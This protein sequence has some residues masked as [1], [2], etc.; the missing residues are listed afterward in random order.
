M[1]DKIAEADKELKRQIDKR[2]EASKLQQQLQTSVDK[3]RA[4]VEEYRANVAE[5]EKSITVEEKEYK[6]LNER[7]LALQAEFKNATQGLRDTQS[8]LASLE[9]SYERSKKELKRRMNFADAEKAKIPEVENDVIDATH[10]LRTLQREYEHIQ[11]HRTK[12]RK[13]VDILVH[14]VLVQES[15][16]TKLAKKLQDTLDVEASL[17]QEKT[18]WNKEEQLAQKQISALKAQRDLRNRELSRTQQR[19]KST[20]EE[21]LVKKLQLTDLTKQANETIAK[22]QNYSKLYES[23]KNERNSYVNAIQASSQALAE[24]KERVKILQNEVEILQNESIAKD[25][26]LSKERLAHADASVQRD[27]LRFETNKAHAT[28]KDKQRDVEQQIVRIDR[29]NSV[30]SNLEKAMLQL[31]KQYEK[32]VEDRNHTGIQLIDR[33]DEL[34]ILYE[35]SNVHEDTMRKGNESLAA[36]DVK[37]R[38]LQVRERDLERELDV[39][40]EKFPKM[41][42]VAEKVLRLQKQLASERKFTEK[43]SVELE[44][45]SH[46]K[47]WQPLEGYDADSDRLSEQVTALEERLNEKR[48]KLLERELVLEELNSLSE[49]LNEK[50]MEGKQT[51]NERVDQVHS[52]QSRLQNVTKKMMSLVSELSMYQAT[53]MKLEEQKAERQKEV[54]EA[55]NRLQRGEVPSE[56]TVYALRRKERY[57]QIQRERKEKLK[58]EERQK[59]MPVQVTRTTAEQRPNAYVPEG[60]AI[61]VPKPYGANAPFKPQKTGST[62]RNIRKPKPKEIEL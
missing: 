40:R 46:H 31:K 61:A 42:Q 36:L 44:N 38:E 11:S 14:K 9:T 17:E 13:D 47:N 25:K 24:M 18:N 56:E 43:L 45:P 53:S 16:E 12:L 62:M 60:E 59:Q 26:A 27:A 6:E 30:I 55:E 34:C 20:D 52:L 7:K 28:Y 10:G 32:A 37:I 8:S 5:L 41:P 58:E 50:A 3:H 54:E 21:L 19:I 2:T 57:Q 23:V 49:N 48:E 33:N 29:L 39:V 22:L 15:G 35:K 4:E 51:T 1:N